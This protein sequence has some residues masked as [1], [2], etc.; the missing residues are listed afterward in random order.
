V[1]AS[2]QKNPHSST[3]SGCQAT[4]TK[5]SPSSISSTRASPFWRFPGSGV[6]QKPRFITLLSSLRSWE[7][8]IGPEP[9][10]FF[11]LG[12]CCQTCVQDFAPQSGFPEGRHHCRVVLN[13]AG[14][15]R[16][17]VPEVLAT[18]WGCGPRRRR[19]YWRLRCID[20]LLLV[21]FCW[22]INI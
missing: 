2:K 5:A 3:T 11:G 4:W 9:S 22:K 17:H 21:S 16:G 8:Q 6:C 18:S 13:D 10:R 15:S 19:P 1:S 14:L 7:W 20:Q 12:L